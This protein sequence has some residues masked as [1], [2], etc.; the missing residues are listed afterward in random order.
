MPYIFFILM[1]LGACAP[2][3]LPLKIQSMDEVAVEE[4]KFTDVRVELVQ[5]PAL[6][7]AKLL[8]SAIAIGLIENGITTSV[9][10]NDLSRFVLKGRAKA[11][12][13]DRRAPF[14]ML[15]YWTLY[16]M[17]GKAIGT[18]T[19]GVR[20]ARWKWE[21][22]DPR[23][24]R[25]V[26]KGAA[27]PLAAMIVEEE[28]NPLP[29]LLLGAGIL[30]KPVIGAPGNGNEALRMAIVNGLRASDVTVIEDSRQASLTITGHVTLQPLG[31][32]LD[33]VLVIWRVETMDG[34]EVGR[35]TQVNNIF[36]G[37]LD[38]VWGDEA[39]KIAEAALIG[40]KRIIGL[41]KTRSAQPIKD[42]GGRP[43]PTPDLEQIPNR[44]A[45][46]PD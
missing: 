22:G 24:I 1:V 41:G 43:M 33:K 3:E 19:Q 31:N 44:T 42:T 26:G 28:E 34:F 25:A 38:G 14:V 16:D 18:Y 29:H 12:W 23:I 17:T 30:V 8:S 13:E 10:P 36:A 4:V 21:F 20:G 40:I 2:N 46:P 15:I 9:K 7:M 32:A 6:P 5:G 37:K 27:K 39:E 11:N 45:P 35:A